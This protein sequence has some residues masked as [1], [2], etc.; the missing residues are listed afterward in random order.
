MCAGNHSMVR[1]RD[2]HPLFLSLTSPQD[3]NHS[4]LLCSNQFDNAIGES[5]PAATLMRID[6]VRPNREDRV[7]H[8]NA[9]SGPRLQIAVIGDPASNIILEFPKDVS[10]RER[11]RPNGRLHGET[12]TMGVTRCWVRILAD[13]QHVDLVVRCDG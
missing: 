2:Q 6:L 9:S 1:L 7:E 8:E 12:Q 11:Q 4:R 5:L 13:E 3:K 10:Q